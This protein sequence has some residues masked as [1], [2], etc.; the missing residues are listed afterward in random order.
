MISRPALPARD[1]ALALAVLSFS[2][3][4]LIAP[5]IVSAH[6]GVLR[7]FVLIISRA[8]SFGGGRQ[9][10]NPTKVLMPDVHPNFLGRSLGNLGALFDLVEATVLLVLVLRLPPKELRVQLFL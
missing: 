3:A 7:R 4:S 9:R 8:G 2:F 5:V 6:L 10:L 1:F